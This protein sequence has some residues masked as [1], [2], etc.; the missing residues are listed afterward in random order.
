MLEN[1]AGMGVPI[2]QKLLNVLDK[3][4]ERS[5]EHLQDKALL[6]KNKTE[7]QIDNE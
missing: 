3:L 1:I 5:Q 2:P 6:E 7:Q 4:S